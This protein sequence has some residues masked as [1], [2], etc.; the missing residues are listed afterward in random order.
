VL[1]AA[2]KTL[3]W[4]AILALGRFW[5]FRVIVLPGSTPIHTGP[6]RYL[7]H[8]NY[9]GVAGELV[10]VAMLAGAPVAGP[11][12]TALF[13]ALMAVRAVV[14]NRTRDAILRRGA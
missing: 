7:R 11:L 1:F 8:P 3:K 9:V 4:W 2:G 13:I 5:T 6:Y 10:G 14:E 12:G